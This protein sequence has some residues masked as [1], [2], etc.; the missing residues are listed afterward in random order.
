[1]EVWSKIII[2]WTKSNS[3]SIF[4]SHKS[5][6]EMIHSNALSTTDQRE[7]R[8]A[9]KLIIDSF[10]N[11]IF[12]CLWIYEAKHECFFVFLNV[13]PFWA[14]ATFGLSCSFARGKSYLLVAINK[15]NYYNRSKAAYF[16]FVCLQWALKPIDSMCSPLVA[17]A[18]ITITKEQKPIKN[19]KEQKCECRQKE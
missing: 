14:A 4:Y 13:F 9:C 7:Y 17:M 11:S 8:V 18:S 19:Q 6:T 3:T 10:W 5:F 1:M 16:N 15:L 2:R 12:C